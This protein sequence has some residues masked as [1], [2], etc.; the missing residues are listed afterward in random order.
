MGLC[1][2]VTSFM[3]IPNPSEVIAGLV[4]NIPDEA[5]AGLVVAGMIGTTMGGILYVTRSITVKQK[6][7]TVSDL[8]LERRDALFSSSLM[9]ILSVAIMAAAAGTLYP[10]GLHVENAIDMI[11]LLEPLAGRFAISVFVA[12]IVCAGIS[13]LFP[14]YMLVPLLL[15]DYNN[16]KFDLG[17]WRNRGIVIFYATLGLVVPIFGGRPVLIMI[18][19][20]A[21]A[22]IVTPLILIL[23]LILQNKEDVLGKYKASLPLNILLVVITLFTIVTAV[24]GF[25]GIV[26][27]I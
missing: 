26:D 1:F 24:I 20:Q 9:F 10:Q 23:M 4:P 16:E 25:I 5:N 11:K 22:L 21:L 3:V 14:H 15:A 18:I 27:L 2:I 8:H 17:K 12:G 7:W 6:N 19:S 13:S